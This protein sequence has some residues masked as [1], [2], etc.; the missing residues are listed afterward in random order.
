MKSAIAIGMSLALLAAC[1]CEMGTR[2]G[3]PAKGE[4]FK[5]VVPAMSQSVKQGEVKTITLKLDRA[6]SFKRD[7]RLIVRPAE[8]LN[9]EPTDILVR[10]SD[11]PDVQ[12]RIGAPQGAALG[13]YRI[14][15]T[16]TPES[17]APSSA[18]FTVKV[19]AP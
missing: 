15:V 3:G 1:G 7:V 10:G 6:E 18:D 9:V 19:V 12:L 8:G 11:K 2:G 17:G 14:Y 16:A 13:D 5:V 4:G